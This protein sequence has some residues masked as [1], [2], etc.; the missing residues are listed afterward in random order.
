M[1]R[2]FPPKRRRLVLSGSLFLRCGDPDGQAEYR[3]R[4]YRFCRCLSGLVQILVQGD[5][6]SWVSRWGCLLEW[7]TGNGPF[8]QPVI[9]EPGTRRIGEGIRIRETDKSPFSGIFLPIRP[10][11][12]FF[13][14]H[15]S[16]KKPGKED[17]FPAVISGG[18]TSPP[19]SGTRASGFQPLPRGRAAWRPSRPNLRR[20][21]CRR[22]IRGFFHRSRLP[23]PASR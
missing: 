11:I 18:V 20:R 21:T 14:K 4:R 10:Q 7:A 3:P 5:G 19:C 22:R 23:R 17:P 9:Q 2:R 8:Q 15:G 6:S 16:M 13:V 1:T 12:S